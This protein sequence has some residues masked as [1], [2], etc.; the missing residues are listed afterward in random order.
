MN[1]FG[2][3]KIRITALKSCFCIGIFIILTKNVKLK[4]VTEAAR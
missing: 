3:L 4:K 2:I 1:V